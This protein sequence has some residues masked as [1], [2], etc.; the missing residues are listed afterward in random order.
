MMSPPYAKNTKKVGLTIGY[1]SEK[2]HFRIY[3]PDF[4]V[5][6]TN[7]DHRLIETKGLVDPEVLR[8]DARA[9]VWCQVAA[10]LTAISPTPQRWRYARINQSTFE[11]HRGN[12]FDSLVRHALVIA[13]PSFSGVDAAPA[14]PDG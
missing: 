12:S 6:L 11:D 9:R 5:R 7:G 4:V 3:E 14:A 2:G 10:D 13:A 1:Q 8:K